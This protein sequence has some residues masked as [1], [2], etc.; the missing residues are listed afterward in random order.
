[1]T[2]D[3]GNSCLRKA[4]APAPWSCG[5][6]E[7]AGAG[8]PAI[9]LGYEVHLEIQQALLRFIAELNERPGAEIRFTSRIE[10][11]WPWIQVG[12]EYHAA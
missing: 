4:V 11:N 3:S 9:S 1:M 12:R 2:G 10:L 5:L 6:V 7:G 8:Y